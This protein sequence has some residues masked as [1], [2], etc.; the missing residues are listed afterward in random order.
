MVIKAKT[1]GQWVRLLSGA[2]RTE[3]HPGGLTPKECTVLALLVHSY[4]KTGSLPDKVLVAALLNQPIQV[5]TNYINKLKKKKAL[6]E[7][8][9]PAA[10]LLQTSVNFS[11]EYDFH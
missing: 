5:V 1:P 6:L 3:K 8:G 11:Q 7:D 10:L 2:F 4:V 9:K